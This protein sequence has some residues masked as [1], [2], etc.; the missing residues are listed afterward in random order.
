MHHGW[1]WFPN[2]PGLVSGIVIG[3]FGMGSFI[4]DF[5]CTALVNPDDLSDVNGK[6][7]EEVNERVPRMMLV[8]IGSNICIV[9]V[10]LLLIFPGRDLTSQKEVNQAI[11]YAQTSEGKVGEQFMEQRP[12]ILSDDDREEK[13]NKRSYSMGGQGDSK[14][15]VK[16]K[17]MSKNLDEI[18][19]S[20]AHAGKLP[21][22]N[23]VKVQF[24]DITNQNAVTNKMDLDK[25]ILIDEQKW[26]LTK[27]CLKTKDYW[28][29]YS[30]QTLSICKL[31][32][33]SLTKIIVF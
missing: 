23:S 8:M 17:V 1:L 6:F 9:A 16:T 10:A 22:E 18:S 21:H 24:I 33:E 32:F 5:V 4:F 31:F 2:R 3:G 19:P 12:L 27:Q 14:L 26:R 11:S 13:I 30:M 25:V 15:R 7:P 28:K 20:V 29:L